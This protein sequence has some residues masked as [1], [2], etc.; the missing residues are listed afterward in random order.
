M[1]TNAEFLLGVL[2]LPNGIPRKDV[3]RRLLCVLKPAAFQECFMTWIE[4]LR[5]VADATCPVDRPILAIDGKTVRRSHD[6]AKGLGPLHSVSVWASDYGLTLA[7]VSTD[8]KSSENA[9]IPAALDLV[10]LKRAIVTVLPQLKMEFVSGRLDKSL[11]GDSTHEFQ[12]SS[13]H[14]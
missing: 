13:L 7:Q 4:S 2:S 3:Y 5:Q 8:E 11:T 12:P 9:A 10:D 6:R 14:T 1:E